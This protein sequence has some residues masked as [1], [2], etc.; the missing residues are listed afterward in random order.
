MKV[1][2]DNPPKS[3]IFEIQQEFY[4]M[5]YIIIHLNGFYNPT[6]L[7]STFFSGNEAVLDYRGFSVAV[8]ECFLFSATLFS[9]TLFRIMVFKFRKS[10]RFLKRFD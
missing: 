2:T 9:A 1:N 8:S 5:G 10:I 7:R 6:P 3:D 4:K